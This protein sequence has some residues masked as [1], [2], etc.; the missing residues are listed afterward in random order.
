MTMEFQF[1]DLRYDSC[2]VLKSDNPK[3]IPLPLSA[4]MLKEEFIDILDKCDQD[5]VLDERATRWGSRGQYLEELRDD[6]L[7]WR[8]VGRIPLTKEWLLEF[9]RLHTNLSV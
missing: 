6:G 7:R 5:G 9:H 4:S 8:R 1:E 3:H 2:Y